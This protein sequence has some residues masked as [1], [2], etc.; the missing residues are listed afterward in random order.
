MQEKMIFKDD[1]EKMY[2][3]YLD[4]ERQFV[5]LS[6]IIPLD[7]KP[8]TYS[9]RLY[10]I[11]HTACGQVENMLR[12]ICDKLELKY[13]NNDFPSYY[14]QLNV[15]GMLER[16]KVILKEANEPIQPFIIKDGKSPDWWKGYN[17]AKHALPEGIVEGNIGNTINA[18][19]GICVLH[20]I[21]YFAVHPPENVLTKENWFEMEI[22]LNNIETP[23]YVVSPSNR[24]DENTMFYAI[25]TYS[26]IHEKHNQNKL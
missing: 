7:N 15:H 5:E 26:G 25:T 21:S 17:K 1:I 14:E 11:F 10:S 2:K 23:A 8:E 13:L 20:Q 24:A 22:D 18:L 3:L 9:P 4:T 12:L 16:H 19:A 6:R